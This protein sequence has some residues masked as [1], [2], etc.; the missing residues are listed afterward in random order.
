MGGIAFTRQAPTRSAALAA[1]KP[2]PTGDRPI[3]PA[4]AAMASDGRSSCGLEAN[5]RARYGGSRH[6]PRTSLDPI[7]VGGGA[8]A[9]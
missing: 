9:K 3:D 7:V 4:L 8:Q 5:S 1:S 6:S 2:E